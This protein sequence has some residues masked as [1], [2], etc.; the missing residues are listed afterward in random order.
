LIRTG[1]R[2]RRNSED[3]DMNT[4]DAE[5]IAADHISKKYIYEF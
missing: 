5:Y 3:S 1:G 4:N 2:A